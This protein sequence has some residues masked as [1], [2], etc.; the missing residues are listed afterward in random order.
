MEKLGVR[1]VVRGFY[2]CKS[3]G[4]GVEVD[5]FKNKEVYGIGVE[6]I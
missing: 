3:Y 4:V 5:M 6:E 2:V 1:I